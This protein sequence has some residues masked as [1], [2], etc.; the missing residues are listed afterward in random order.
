MRTG[1]GHPTKVPP[2]VRQST[3]R[4]NKV[5]IRAVRPGPGGPS[6]QA[7]LEDRACLLGIV[8]DERERR[9][10]APAAEE[11]VAQH[12]HPGVGE[13]ARDPGHA[14]RPVV[15]LGQERLALEEGPAAVLE[16]LAGA[17]VVGRGHDEVADLAQAAA[18][19]RAQVDAGR[20]HR[21]GEP[22]HLAGL[23][24]DL[25]DEL[26]GHRGLRAA[27]CRGW[28]RDGEVILAWPVGGR[29]PGGPTVAIPGGWRWRAGRPR[30]TSAR[31]P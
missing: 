13:L 15:H 19:D 14:A 27:G 22:G 9:P 24:G 17:V 23:V 1:S 26:P 25:D 10:I 16:D 20:R 7:A 21:F 2:P 6:R 4:G 31:S 5:P 12:V 30:G 11:Q 29:S 3:Y 28:G 8:N 18:A